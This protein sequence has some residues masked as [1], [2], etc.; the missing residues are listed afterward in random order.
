M[1]STMK[2]K[3]EEPQGTIKNYFLDKANDSPLP[4]RTL[5]MIQPSAAGSLVGRVNEA[6]SM[7]ASSKRK[8][9]NDQLISKSSNTDVAVEPEHSENENLE[10]VSQE[11]FD[12]MIKENPPSQYW[13]EVAEKR[14][15]VLYEVLQENEKLHKEIEQKDNEIAHLKEENKELVELAGHVQ[16]MAD[17]IERLTGQSVENFELRDNLAFEDS[18]SGR[19]EVDKDSEENSE[20]NT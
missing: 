14:R 20:I 1:N 13:K 5:K 11:A 2:Q 15:K 10:G 4:R 17:I 19:E 6:N 12:L 18:D 16:Y 8:L 9:W 3:R 7:K